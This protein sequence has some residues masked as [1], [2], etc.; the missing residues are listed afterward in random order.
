M[1]ATTQFYKVKSRQW[2]AN[3]RTPIIYTINFGNLNQVSYKSAE[4]KLEKPSFTKKVSW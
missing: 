2:T 1:T 3:P 4:G